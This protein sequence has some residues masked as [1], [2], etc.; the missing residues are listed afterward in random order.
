MFI[1]PRAQFV[2]GLSFTAVIDFFV[3]LRLTVCVAPEV[4][5]EV[6]DEAG[7]SCLLK[8]GKH[9]MTLTAHQ[10]CSPLSQISS[11]KTEMFWVLVASAA[12]SVFHTQETF[13]AAAVLLPTSA[14]SF[15][16]KVVTCLVFLAQVP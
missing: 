9:Y 4:C 2:L 15:K 10:A 16:Q 3:S 7:H 14:L 1:V 8:K 13:A 11:I 12:I 6:R 5:S